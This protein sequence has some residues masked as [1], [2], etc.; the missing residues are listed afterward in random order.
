MCWEWG[1]HP[2]DAEGQRRGPRCQA[3]AAQLLLFLGVGGRAQGLLFCAALRGVVAHSGR[4]AVG[5]VKLSGSG[6]SAA[7]PSCAGE[8][9][10]LKEKAPVF[11]VTL[12]LGA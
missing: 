9:L 10:V 3:V 2:T 6:D 4:R 11:L 8:L 7:G 5:I 12:V 1:G